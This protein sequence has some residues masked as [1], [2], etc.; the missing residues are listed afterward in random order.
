MTFITILIFKIFIVYGSFLLYIYYSME[1]VY[2]FV[3]Y[4]RIVL[5]FSASKS[6]FSFQ[7]Y[8]CCKLGMTVL[9]CPLRFGS[10]KIY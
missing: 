3:H 10:A 5:D 2:I 9:I 8:L 1:L 7:I 6:S 4:S